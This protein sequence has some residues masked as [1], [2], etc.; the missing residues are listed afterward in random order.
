[1][2]PI[3]LAKHHTSLR[4]V[5]ITWRRNKHILTSSRRPRAEEAATVQVKLDEEHHWFDNS[6]R[7]EPPARDV[8][9]R[10]RAELFFCFLKLFLEF[11]FSNSFGGVGI[12]TED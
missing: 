7:Q 3:R 12:G 9:N 10:L 5:T 4:L 2:P 8:G 6:S 11:S 1:M